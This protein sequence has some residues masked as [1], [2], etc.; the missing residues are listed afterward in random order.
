MNKINFENLPS[1]TMPLNAESLNT[2]QDNIEAEIE[3]KISKE[4]A[5][6]TG[7]LNDIKTTGFTY[8][9]GTATNIP[10]SGHFYF[11]TT[12]A[13]NENNIYQ[14]ATRLIADI[15]SMLTYERQCVSGTWTEWYECE[16]KFARNI[17]ASTNFDSVTIPGKYYFTSTP[18]GENKPVAKYGVLEVFGNSGSFRMQRFTV[19]DGSEVYTR[20]GHSG[21]WSEWKA[22]SQNITT[23]TEFETGRIIDGK[24]E[25]AKRIDIGALPNATSKTVSHG[26]NLS[27]I[28]FTASPTGV[29]SQSSGYTIPIPSISTSAQS[30]NVALLVEPTTIKI[31]TVQDYSAYTGNVELKYT[32]NS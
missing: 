4:L 15:D 18:S 9:R 13:I 24:K 14:R 2:M 12:I 27:N 31:T 26:L 5:S 20:G 6:Y 25:Y 7:D 28:K 19:Y 21:N 29:A 8:A 32:K 30:W 1:T 11:L 10:V 23:G 16:A 22:T 17:S 3:K